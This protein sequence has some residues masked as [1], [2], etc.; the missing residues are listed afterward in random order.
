MERYD[1]GGDIFS[2]RVELDFSVNVNPLGMPPAVRQ[3]LIEGID[4]FASYPDPQCRALR[5]ALAQRHS[6]S[7]ARILC[8]AGAADLIIR[9]CLVR[10]PRRVL[11]C[12]PTFSEYEKAALLSGADVVYH[13]LFEENNFDLGEDF[14]DALKDSV[15]MVFLC[16]PNNPTGRLIPQDFLAEAARICQK[17]GILLAVDECFLS[18]TDAPSIRLLIA[19]NPSLIVIDAFTKMYAIAGLRLGYIMSSN[20]DLLS[21]V[22]AFGQSWSVSAPAQTAGLAALECGEEWTRKTRIVTAA[23]RRFVS[24][25][26]ALLGMNVFDGAAN[27]I[28]FKSPA[29]LYEPLLARGILIRSCAN[30]TGLDASFYRVGVK[31]RRDNERLLDELR[32]IVGLQSA[33]DQ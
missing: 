28:L 1:H 26:L 18:F 13:R 29:A 16:S 17:R 15:D 4:S 30:Y 11:V 22:E 3:A 9:L 23:E 2:R 7:P 10:R 25:G 12:A 14:L 5:A 27:Y 20:E 8:G 21:R 19:Q 24:E 32:A 33:N 31:M 6:C